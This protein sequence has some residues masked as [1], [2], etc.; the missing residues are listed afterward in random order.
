MSRAEV[1]REHKETEGDPLHKS[2]RRRMHREIVQQRMISEVRR[3]QVVV[4]DGERV[5]VALSYEPDGESAPLVVAK[6]ERLV[7]LL[8]TNVAREAGVPVVAHSS[9]AQSLGVVG[10][11]DEIPE[12]AFEAVACLLAR[13]SEDS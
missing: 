8:I 10:E 6:G 5:A 9:L 2:E 12:S 4:V 11:G 7:A 13:S 1:M 3:A